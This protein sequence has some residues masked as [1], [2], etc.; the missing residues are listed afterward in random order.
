MFPDTAGTEPDRCGWCGVTIGTICDPATSGWEISSL[1]IA[2]S[3]V[4]ME[5]QQAGGGTTTLG[6]YQAGEGLL[7]G[8]ASP[9]ALF[10]PLTQSRYVRCSAYNAKFGNKPPHKIPEKSEGPFGA[11]RRGKQRLRMVQ[12]I[13]DL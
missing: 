11:E 8:A 12:Q 10:H 2:V 7:G 1:L 9:A 5:R 4:I 3:L 13:H 6:R